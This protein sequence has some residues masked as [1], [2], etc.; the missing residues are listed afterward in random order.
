MDFDPR[1]FGFT[2][3]LE[4]FWAGRRP[5]RPT[6]KRQYMSA[7]FFHD[8]AQKRLAEESLLKASAG[9]EGEIYVE[10]LS[11]DSFFPAEDYHQKFYL[12]RHEE[13]MADLRA[14]YPDFEDLVRSTAA[15]RLNGYLGGS[16]IQQLDGEDLSRFGL[17]ERA[18]RV[19]RASIR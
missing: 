3:L 13:L 19:L 12:Q 7:I 15:A 6:F 5:T 11:A 10:I 9:L 14:A 17:S 1:V 16:R 4:L 18:Q 2:D 8:D